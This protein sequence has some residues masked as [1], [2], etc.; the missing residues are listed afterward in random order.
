[1]VVLVLLVLVFMLVWS[2]ATL[3]IDAWLRR[4]RR[5]GLVERLMP[6]QPPS[7]ADE[8]QEW[9]DRQDDQASS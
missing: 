9:L 4:P 1:V 7:L 2:G 5:L 3:L 6:F 8:A